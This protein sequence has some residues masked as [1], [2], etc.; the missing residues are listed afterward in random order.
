MKPVRSDVSRR[1]FGFTLVELLVVIGIIAL[2]ISILLPSLNAARRAAQS[3][4][5]E[6]NLRSIGQAIAL[7]ANVGTNRG[8]L[9]FGTWNGRPDGDFN[10]YGTSACDWSTVLANVMNPKFP[11]DYIDA[12]LFTKGN[13]NNGL[14]N[15]FTC[16][17]ARQP[18]SNG[19]LLLHYTCHP[20]LMPDITYDQ[21]NDTANGPTPSHGAYRFQPYK[22]TQIK[23]QSEIALIWDGSQTP[24]GG[25]TGQW[26]ASALGDQLDAGR[27]YG[28]DGNWL[29]D[30][31]AH[32]SAIQ[33]YLVGSYPADT[34]AMNSNT[35]YWNTD[36]TQN[37]DQIRFRH[38]KNN[39]ANVLFVDGHV[40]PKHAKGPTDG[41]FLRSNIQVP[42]LRSTRITG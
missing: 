14:L 40:E 11:I 32:T 2:L 39:T 28:W 20:R 24:D 23:R 26:N 29:C 5:C 1:R 34:S 6:S 3:I 7:Y 33:Y 41:D 18:Q 35:P 30:D 10:Y 31:P 37:P 21:D 13:L 4:K 12:G 16:P 25:G 36:T 9:P 19:A 42:F 27:I 8:S 22:L 38:G 15:I 17:S